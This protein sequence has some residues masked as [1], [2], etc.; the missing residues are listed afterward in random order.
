MTGTALWIAGFAGLLVW[1]V[2]STRRARGR[3]DEIVPR[4]AVIAAV[5]AV[6]TLG[7]SA[8]YVWGVGVADRG[9]ARIQSADREPGGE[10]I[11]AEPP[12]ARLFLRHVQMQLTGADG[13][14][15]EARIGYSPEADMRLPRSYG[16][17]EAKQG[18][19]LALARA[20]GPQGLQVE[21]VEHPEATGTRTLIYARRRAIGAAPSPASI[22]K[23][24]RALTGRG[25]ARCRATESTGSAQLDGPGALYVVLCRGRTPVAALVL[26][27]DLVNAEGAISTALRVNP[28]VWRGGQW[29]PHHVQITSG[30]LIQIGTMAD[31][32]P[33]VTLWEVPAPSGR[34]ELFY[35]P[36]NLLASCPEWLSGHKRQ[37]FFSYPGHAS[38]RAPPDPASDTDG[39][40][41]DDSICVLP[42][43]PP[44]GM[45]VR[46]LLP[47]LPGIAARSLWAAGLFTTPALL[48]LLLLCTRARSQLTR[49]RFRRLLGVSWLAVFLCAVAVWRLLWAHRIDMLRDYEAVGARVLQNQLLLTL[50][51]A[52]LAAT[53]ALAWWSAKER[54]RLRA[55]LPALAAWLIALA[56][57]GYA[58]RGDLAGMELS[59][60]DLDMRLAG[61][62][63]L[64]LAI[65]GA[66][67]WLPP[68][69]ATLTRLATR[70][71]G[72]LIED[73]S[74]YPW[75]L[76]MGALVGVCVLAVLADAL[77]PR[78]VLLKL[79]LA[80]SYVLA[81]YAAL[82]AASSNTSGPAWR[83]PAVLAATMAVGLIGAG[84]LARF[85]PGVT[86]AIA[87]PGLISALLFASH[88]ARFADSALPM[89]ASYRRH[90][91]PL[92][93][94]HAGLFLALG[95]FVV[96]WSLSGLWSTGDREPDAMLSRALT[97]G[98][99]HLLWFF[100]L[101]FAAA[102]ALGYLRRGL[103]AAVPWLLI[104]AFLAGA[105]L[106]RNTIIDRVL[107]SS[108][109]AANRI[110][111]VLDPGYALLRSE[112][113]FSSGI[114]AWRE[115]IMPS[116]GG[117]LTGGELW[118]GQG[119]FGAQLIDPGVLLSVENDYFPV[120]LLRE[121]GI[122]GILATGLLLF[123]L[124]T[125]AWLLAGARFR[126][127]SRAQRGRAL[128][129][130][131][132][133]VVCV[134][135]PLAALGVLPLTGI[136]WPGFG[137]DSPSDFW[138]LFALIAWVVLWGEPAAD[139]D[140]EEFDHELRK[141]RL[142]RQVRG[143]VA[144]TAALCVLASLLL[145]VRASAFAL[146]RPNPVDAN[147]HAVKPFDGLERAVDYA[148]HLQCPWR[149]K[150]VEGDADS[151][152]DSDANAHARSLVPDDLLGDAPPGG[153]FRFHSALRT[154]WRNQRGRALTEVARFLRGEPACGAKGRQRAGSW[155]FE[156]SPED[157][158][159]CRMRFKFGWPQVEVVVARGRPI[160]APP[161]T[162]APAKKPAAE[163][164]EATPV[165]S[166]PVH[167]ARCTVDVRT[168]IVRKLRFPARRPYRNARIRL[169]SK[170][171]GDA[172]R[173][174]GELLSGHLAVRLRPGAGTAD[175]ARARA[176]MYFAD[177]V[178]ISSHLTIKVIDGVAVLQKRA[179]PA[180]DGD[181]S[182]NNRE[183]WLLL[184]EP[185]PADEP[186]LI[187]VL[188]AEQ[189]RWKLLPPE[190][191]IPLTRLALLVIGGP[192]ARSLW[193]F[194]PPSAWP[195][196]SE[197][198]GPL[199]ADDVTTVR[200]E[201]R[202]HY[203]FGG[204][205]PEIGWVNPYHARMSLGLDGWVRVAMSE[206]EQGPGIGAP[207]GSAPTR[208]QSGPTAQVG[209]RTGAA[210][211]WIDSGA[212]VPYCGPLAVRNA[213]LLA[214]AR[215]SPSTGP[216]PPSRAI[217]PTL[218][219]V[220]QHSS[221]DGVL[222]CR[223]SV[224]PELSIRLRHLT[225]LI[226][227]APTDYS[228]DKKAA[229][230]VRSNFAL[231]RGDTG[232]IV[233]QGEFVPGRASSAYAPATPEIEQHLIR[234]REDRDPKTGRRLATRG[235]ASAEKIDWS[236]PIA[237][238]ST[239]KPILGRAL[240]LADP[241]LARNLV[242]EGSKIAGARC[243]RVRTHAIFGH[244]P[245]TD[246][247]WSRA[248]LTD[249]SR[250]ISASINWYQATI[251][252]LGTAA[253]QRGSLG[254]GDDESERDTAT[255]I[256]RNVGNYRLD[257]AL[258]TRYRSK[259]VLNSNRTIRIDNLRTTPLW[260]RFEELL[261]RPLCTARSKG[262][263][264]RVSARKDLCAARAL[265]IIN[266]TND[267]RHLVALGPSTFDFYPQLA[268]RKKRVGPSVNTR[269]YLQ[270][271]RG[272]G[273]HP[274][275]SLA[276]LTD[277]FNRLVYQ[278]DW[279]SDRGANERGAG[280]LAASW[281]PTAAVGAPPP[282]TCDQIRSERDVA[283]GLC[284]VVRS[285]TA[286][287]ALGPLLTDAR[288]TLYGAKTGTIDSLADIAEK[289]EPCAHFA[290]GHTVPDKAQNKAQ[291]PYWLPC[292]KRRKS[293][294]AVNDS[295]LIVSFAVRTV[296]DEQIPL[297]L[298]LRFQRSG[299][300][301][302]ARVAR[303]YLDVIHD[304]LAAPTAPASSPI[305]SDSRPTS[306]N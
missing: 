4:S 79:S 267:L 164:T 130:V 5:L 30:S 285:G 229:L 232:E 104:A 220:C 235:E 16:L 187:Q 111:I 305:P 57:G 25:R 273:L 179:Q 78:A 91:A 274:L 15:H 118:S 65:G 142:F 106:A 55:L 163:A 228:G 160:D 190:D 259:P 247:L 153:I 81:L 58:L 291:Q 299:P 35:P 165:P 11:S 173:D 1:L 46:R 205:V 166:G 157:Q 296:A 197:A 295:L 123:I 294:V 217:D 277:A 151:D 87:G 234:L 88:D 191:T 240:E 107:S 194:R 275:G 105:W 246:S 162:E 271:L 181:A 175:V 263:C 80:W 238:G 39:S 279:R 304:Y 138:A 221:L 115:T 186:G 71:L 103:R 2:M 270:F 49:R 54:Q 96:I 248:G 33:G 94:A 117:S 185:P 68:A 183:A 300:G 73:T 72:R 195:G 120:L 61:Q 184:R 36:Q 306:P 193:L 265:P 269:E 188:E 223:V 59:G 233:A 76:S 31:A 215:M 109:Q 288:F 301:L 196:E 280:R 131:V 62:I 243:R 209:A 214:N 252:L 66:L 152:A 43:T 264:R 282:W 29:R 204:M 119:Y 256:G 297:T 245:P 108:T 227:L 207:A 40:H 22:A 239:V 290:T 208:P 225:E 63:F 113:K 159:E 32:L 303:H 60:V 125:G 6:A 266:P 210:P 230:P 53:C 93:L 255:V 69:R 139:G 149:Q 27:R 83:A 155:T 203:L 51:G 132:L 144:A 258:W 251:G 302:A 213:P 293:L 19:D 199:I 253:G 278:Y 42:F 86:V 28:L 82:R 201:R 37:G 222:E 216:E 237:V 262:V 38:E 268:D 200:G 143:A 90:H 64:S 168:D 114:T 250:F 244:C 129:A 154:R 50:G 110:A 170:A 70:P 48:L 8:A 140:L 145:S 286:D 202:R 100:G 236:Q 150:S 84:L 77:A 231:M 121:L 134:Y 198:V 298:G 12:R 95:L 102:G 133:G 219:R 189:G 176:G 75:L 41:R 211:T 92:I 128:I 272:S 224:Q 172:A 9:M 249:M 3:G 177:T 98:A 7:F 167:S 45:E 136:S 241:E 56:V 171:M 99:I 20:Q 192:D 24:A 34:A 10:R 122:G 178:H 141:T 292:T 180:P 52:T 169:V 287:S 146:R 261:G 112:S 137:L 44:F 147:G 101:L 206:Y 242:I 97:L 127:G 257:E 47:D 281:F 218:A 284:E 174:R 116:D 289:K 158:N 276:Q 182:D 17:E 156:R 124:V 23:E 85:D 14:T 67:G 126:H 18:W 135:Q 254:F 212:R 74:V 226:S 148:F 161:A 89:M 283:A 21:A 260:Q 13:G 26:E